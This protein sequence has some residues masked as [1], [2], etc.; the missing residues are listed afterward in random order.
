MDILDVGIFP[1]GAI[2]V[3]CFLFCLIV[4]TTNKLDKYIPP[5]C[6]LSGCLLGLIWFLSGWPGITAQDPI[7][8]A[9]IGVVSGLA[10]TGVHQIGKQLKDK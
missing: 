7:T 2:T 5:V 4:K 3:I 1:I 9:A 10:A 6:G 8:A